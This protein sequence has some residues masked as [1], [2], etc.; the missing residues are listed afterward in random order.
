MPSWQSRFFSR[1]IEKLVRRRKW[2]G[3][4]RIK[5]LSRMVFGAPAPYA[6]LSSLG[7]KVVKST[8]AAGEWI[9]PSEPRRG[10]IFYIHG[11]GYVSCSPRTHRPITAALARRTHRKVFS[12]DYRRAPESRFPAALEDVIAGYQ[13]LLANIP[14]DEPV[15]VAG[16][17]AG[18]GLALALAM[19]ARDAGLTPPVCLVLFSPWTDLE[20]TGASLARN[21]GKCVMFRA[22]NIRQFAKVYLGNESPRNPKASPLFGAASNLP[23]V[24]FQVGV[25]EVLLDDS[26]RIHE[27][28]LQ[29]AGYSELLLNDSFHGMQVATPIIPEARESLQLAAEFVIAHLERA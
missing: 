9:N 7:L 17:S 23:P 28:I 25:D 12:V 16:D 21:D 2:G 19:H 20:G 8:G 29:T 22:E 6:W 27:R 14:V 18:G 10:V 24:Q 13:Y 3:D 4:T 11:G 26:V 15:A 5:L 1:V